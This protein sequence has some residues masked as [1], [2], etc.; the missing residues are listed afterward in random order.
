MKNNLKKLSQYGVEICIAFLIV[1]ALNKFVILNAQIPSASME[2]TI[3]TGEKLIA[4][5]LSYTAHDPERYDIAVF[6]YPDNPSLLFIKR[7]IGLPGEK[8]EIKDG[9]VYINNSTTPLDD[10]FCQEQ[11]S[12]D[13]GPYEIPEGNYFMMGDNREHSDDSRFWN[14]HYVSKDKIIGKAVFSYYPKIEK[15]K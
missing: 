2:E 3:L 15:I 12:G 13:F 1:I 10:S 4:S 14:N 9:K 6:R 5:R 11:P 8:L 7:V